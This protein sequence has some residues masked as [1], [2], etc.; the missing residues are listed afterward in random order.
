[1]LAQI[2]CLL[3]F[4]DIPSFGH[5]IE[6]VLIRIIIKELD[7]FGLSLSPLDIFIFL[8]LFLDPLIHPSLSVYNLRARLK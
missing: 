4:I 1:M 3:Q 8:Q 7:F 5:F 2:V 6:F